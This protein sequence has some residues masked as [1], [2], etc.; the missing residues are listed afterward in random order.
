M[1]LWMMSLAAAVM[2]VNGGCAPIVLGLGEE[3]E[4]EPGGE[5]PSR[6]AIAVRFG[7]TSSD[8]SSAEVVLNGL[9]F[10]RPPH[11]DSLALFFSDSEQECSRP[12]IGQA[13]NGLAFNSTSPSFWQIALFI[14]PEL[15]RPGLID[16][17]DYRITSYTAVW[18]TS[19][20]GGTSTGPGTLA[21]SGGVEEKTLEIVS[22]DASSVSV[23]LHWGTPPWRI[24]FNGQPY[25][26]DLDLGG[27]YTATYC[28]DPP[29]PS[30]P[31]PGRAVPGAALA[32][33]PGGPTPDPD[34]LHL[35][36]GSAAESCADPWSSIACTGTYRVTLSL[37]PAYQKPGIFDLTDPAIAASFTRSVSTECAAGDLVTD[38]FDGGTIEILSIDAT[39][40]SCRVYGSHTQLTHGG[41]DADG[42]YAASSCP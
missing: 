28:G 17:R 37:P 2:I 14:P 36:L 22:S 5:P 23:K 8:P 3:P 27:D 1:K 38:V 34:A 30:L 11:P 32:A 9:Q 35:F 21:T 10:Q 7:D 18:A 6:N 20:G 15:N 39:G 31:S 26:P 40:V 33:P 12:L 42:L 19:L 16:L 25:E 24:K 29:P 13:R 4:E 41:F